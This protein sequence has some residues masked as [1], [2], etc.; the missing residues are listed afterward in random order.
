VAADWGP[1]HN[2]DKRSD[3]MR[4]TRA[5]SYCK[6]LGSVRPRPRPATMVTVAAQ[7]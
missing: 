2:S 6:P 7:E 3:M 4:W 5:Q 1:L